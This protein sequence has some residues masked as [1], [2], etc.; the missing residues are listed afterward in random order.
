MHHNQIQIY[1]PNWWLVREETYR[2][3]VNSSTRM[4]KNIKKIKFHET[5]NVRFEIM[6]IREE[7]ETNAKLNTS[8]HTP[9]N[10]TKC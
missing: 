7:E 5:W 4:Q 2:I 8:I 9:L 6:N 1:K 3:V 10:Q